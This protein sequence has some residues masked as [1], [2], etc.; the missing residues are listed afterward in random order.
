MAFQRKEK[1][2]PI[3]DQRVRVDLNVSLPFTTIQ[4]RVI[5]DPPSVCIVD[6]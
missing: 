5:S 4:C 3:G 1:L 2:T 6:E